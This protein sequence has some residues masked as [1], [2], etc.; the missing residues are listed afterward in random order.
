M[1]NPEVPSFVPSSSLASKWT[2][3]VNGLTKPAT[4]KEEDDQKGPTLLKLTD[5]RGG[6]GHWV[7]EVGPAQ[8]TDPVPDDGGVGGRG[9]EGGGGGQ[10]AGDGDEVF[11]AGD[12][13]VK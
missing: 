1:E 6:R 11:V 7:G 4:K 10:D 5:N 12:V 2:P 9:G 8:A 3:T 13:A